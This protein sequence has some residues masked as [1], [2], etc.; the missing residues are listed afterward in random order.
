MPKNSGVIEV[1]PRKG[2][3]TETCCHQKYQLAPAVTKNA[4]ARNFE[5]SFHFVRIANRSFSTIIKKLSTS[6]R[7]YAS[8]AHCDDRLWHLSDMARCP[9]RVR[10]VR[11]N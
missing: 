2:N 5:I 7:P 8:D 9:A 11:P 6:L 3:G 4:P 10:F 1:K